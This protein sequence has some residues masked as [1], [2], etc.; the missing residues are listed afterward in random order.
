MANTKKDYEF[1]SIFLQG[2]EPPSISVPRSTT[3]QLEAVLPV[4]EEGV[5][6]VKSVE[7]QLFKFGDANTG[8]ISN[9][10]VF[11]AP[12][13]L[14]KVLVSCYS[15]NYDVKGFMVLKIV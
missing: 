12:P 5:A 4:Y 14:G 6:E 9:T 2:E 11:N 10:G 3:V 7:W 1:I 13:T 15:H 8:T